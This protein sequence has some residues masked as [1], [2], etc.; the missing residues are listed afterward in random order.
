MTKSEL[1]RL[2]REEFRKLWESA[3]EGDPLD[4]LIFVCAGHLGMRASE[5]AHLKK[6]WIDFQGETVEVPKEDEEFHANGSSR[7]ISFKH[8]RE[9]VTIELR[10]YFDYNEIVGVN[11]ATI[12]RRVKNMAQRAELTRQVNPQA[13]RA[14]CAFQ[15]AEAGVNAQGLR[16]FMGWKDLNTAQKYIEQVGVD[17]DKQI[18][19]NKDKLW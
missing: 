5:I 4:R 7:S 15:L 8:L 11:R 9:R 1:E 2:D 6:D 3:V 19:R 13:L 18:K 10:R 17:A 14:T 16:K 12:F